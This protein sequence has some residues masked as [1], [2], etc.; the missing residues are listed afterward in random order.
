MN[1]ANAD[2]AKNQKYKC[3]QRLRAGYTTLANR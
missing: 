2:T 1:Y 3:L